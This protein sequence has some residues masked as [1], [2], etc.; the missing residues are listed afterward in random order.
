M[1]IYD[2]LCGACGAF[3]AF[4]PM[5][6]F[7]A[8]QACPSCGAAAA[9]AMLSAPNLQGKTPSRFAADAVEGGGGGAPHAASCRWRQQARASGG[10]GREAPDPMS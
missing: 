5:A 3:T 7:K 8:P 6:L 9:R 1:P 2:Y 10:R 4:A